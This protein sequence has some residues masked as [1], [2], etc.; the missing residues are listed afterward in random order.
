MSNSTAADASTSSKSDFPRWVGVMLNSSVGAKLAVAVTGMLLVGFVLVHMLGN[1]QILVGLFDRELAVDML[2]G[3]AEHLKSLGPLLWVARGSLLLILLIHLTLALRL[4]VKNRDARPIRYEYERTLV[5]T[6]AART[7]WLTG[8][9]I[10]AFIVFHL[11]HFSFGWIDSAPAEVQGTPG[12]TNLRALREVNDGKERHDVYTMV[13]VGFRNV[14]VS[15][16]YIIAQ[17][18][19]GAHL[20]H[21]TRSMFQTLG[22]NHV[23]Y[24]RAIRGLA[25]AVTGAIVAGNIL[26]PLTVM[27]RILK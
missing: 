12:G 16:S 4:F 11:M 21:G 9:V 2:N 17:L 25:Y 13:I 8:L 1:I 5:A 15:I 6:M 20:I 24:N 27:F 22:I 19:L 3:Y 10:L 14:P 23:K 26:M 7:M 18:F